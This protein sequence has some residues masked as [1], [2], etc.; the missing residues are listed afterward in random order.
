VS[1]LTPG[2]RDTSPGGSY[3]TPGAGAAAKGVRMQ[4]EFPQ[5]FR[6]RDLDAAPP[7]AVRSLGPPATMSFRLAIVTSCGRAACRRKESPLSSLMVDLI[8]IIVRRS[9]AMSLKPC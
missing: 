4:A 2:H 9:G 1:R 5:G 6:F 7:T 8:G 3:G